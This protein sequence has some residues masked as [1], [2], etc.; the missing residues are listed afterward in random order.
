MMA[1][2]ETNAQRA[3]FGTLP[4]LVD[5]AL[6]RRRSGGR[7]QGSTPGRDNDLRALEGLTSECID[8]MDLMALR[9]GSIS[10]TAE[11]ERRLAHLGTCPHCQGVYR[12][13]RDLMQGSGPLPAQNEEVQRPLPLVPLPKEQDGMPVVR[14]SSGWSDLLA[15]LR[16]PAPA[17]A[18]GAGVGA[19][20]T[21]LL[22]YCFVWL[23]TQLPADADRPDQDRP[24]PIMQPGKRSERSEGPVTTTPSGIADGRLRTYEIDPNAPLPAAQL[25]ERARLNTDLLLLGASVRGRQD[26][27]YVWQAT[28]RPLRDCRLIARF[29]LYKADSR[30]PEGHAYVDFGRVKAG[31]EL[32]YR[33]LFPAPYSEVKIDDYYV[34][35]TE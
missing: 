6:R 4:L 9:A 1:T 31:Q 10:N 34:S 19:A 30:L 20:A 21:T 22:A 27:R 32:T 23:P 14:R 7:Q 28:V 17:F 12:D 18:A 3:E 33:A 24:A 11:R 35:E 13:V 26:D 2:T 15:P 5:A 16:R 25:G 8:P 29:V